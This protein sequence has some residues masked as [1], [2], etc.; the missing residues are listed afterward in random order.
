M[1][2]TATH[3]SIRSSLQFDYI[4]ARLA[5][6]AAYARALNEMNLFNRIK[7]MHDDMSR[8]FNSENAPQKKGNVFF[9][10]LSY[11]TESFFSAPFLEDNESYK[12][13]CEIAS[14]LSANRIRE[15]LDNALKMTFGE[16]LNR[17][18]NKIEILDDY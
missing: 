17:P 1:K 5:H 4:Q 18:K 12:S 8:R 7:E 3:T 14:E 11:D 6:I 9:S 16:Q 13:A 10:Q 2:Y 15:L